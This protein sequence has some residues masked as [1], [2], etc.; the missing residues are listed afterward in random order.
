MCRMISRISVASNPIL[1]EMLTCP[2]SLK[3]LSE[4]GRQPNDP[5][6]RGKHND[7][8]G[9][10]FSTNGSLEVHRRSRENAWDESYISLAKTVSSNI[11]LA[12]N[13]LASKGLE[14]NEKGAHPFSI[15]AAGQTF[16]LCHNGSIYDFME[17]AKKEQTSDSMIFLRK[18]I[19][20][21]GNNNSESIATRLAAI[22]KDATYSSLCSFL[23]SPDQ[24]FVW[25]IYNDS[26]PEKKDQY[27]KYYT[28]HMLQRSNATLFSSEPLTDEPWS[29][30][31]N[32]SLLHLRL[33]DGKIVTE[34]HML[35]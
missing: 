3:Y 9:M 6:V 26:E 25:R 20:V 13:R 15:T 11:F 16:A 30:L 23:I 18:L 12:H 24:L 35:R 14:A 8:C 28:I 29:L 33:K 32:H 19:D 4:N 5:A 27:E 17:E 34:Y 7:G 21:T 1:E 10:A 31:Q 2:H 22:A